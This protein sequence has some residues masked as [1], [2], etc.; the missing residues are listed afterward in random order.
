MIFETENLLVRKLVS[1]NLEAF[2]IM[3]SNPEV[4]QYKLVL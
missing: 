3:Q 1:S 2:H 4:M